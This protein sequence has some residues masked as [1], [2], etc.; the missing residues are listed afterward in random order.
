MPKASEP[1]AIQAKVRDIPT[2]SKTTDEDKVARTA[3][4]RRST[5]SPRGTI[6]SI[7][8]A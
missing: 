1:T 2:A 8:S 3:N 5:M 4:L 6:V 7:P